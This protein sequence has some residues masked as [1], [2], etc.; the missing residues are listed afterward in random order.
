MQTVFS[1]QGKKWF[2]VDSSL[3]PPDTIGS[4]P[5]NFLVQNLIPERPPL[6]PP[7]VPTSDR[8]RTRFM[9]FMN[10]DQKMEPY[11]TNTPKHNKLKTLRKPV[12]KSSNDPLLKIKPT[13]LRL[14]AKATK[15]FGGG[16][17]QAFAVR[18]HILH[19]ADISRIP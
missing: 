8:E 1:G 14:M 17:A 18:K 19:G 4:N 12:D 6:G 7:T 13:F 9:T 16:I 2:E 15:Y 10:W 5:F 11:S 3:L